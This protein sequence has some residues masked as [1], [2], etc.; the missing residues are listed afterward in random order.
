MIA[1]PAAAAVYYAASKGG[2]ADG[3]TLAVYDLGGGT[4]D[5]T[6]VQS[7]AEGIV[8]LGY[9]GDR[10]SRRQQ[11][12]RSDV[13]A[14]QRRHRRRAARARLRRRRRPGGHPGADRADAAALR[15]RQGSA[16]RATPPPPS[17]VVLPG[18]YQS[19]PLTREQFERMIRGWLEDTIALL[20]RTLHSAHVPAEQLSA[21]LLVG[22]SSRI[23]LVQQ[24]VAEA[25][26][27]PGRRHPP[28]IRRRPGRGDA[29]PRLRHRRDA[30]PRPAAPP[31]GR[32]RLGRP[33]ETMVLPPVPGPAT[34]GTGHDPATPC[35][36]TPRPAITAA[37]RARPG[38]PRTGRAG[39][40]PTPPT[41]PDMHRPRLADPDIPATTEGT[42][43]DAGGGG[44]DTD[45]PVP[46]PAR[47]A[48]SAGAA[49]RGA[50]PAKHRRWRSAQCSWFVA[51][52]L[53]AVRP[54]D[55]AG[56]AAGRGRPRPRPGAVAVPGA[57]P[58][59]CRRKRR[60]R[61]AADPPTGFPAI[62]ASSATP[63]TRATIN[64]GPTPG[65]A[66]AQ[67]RYV[68]IAQRASEDGSRSS[69]P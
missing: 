42:R 54:S 59:P 7:C 8:V 29:G 11:L 26:G 13:R 16:V 52:A 68:Y 23:P 25:F 48:G 45:P 30:G 53:C 5:A 43:L 46:P 21:V 1:E 57:N 15:G 35:R 51:A 64:V 18:L 49:A 14:L 55:V 24:M 31:R 69:T 60:P 36:P 61:T 17:P 38:G 40:L 33:E 19:V 50:V 10:A 20:Q 22:A 4:F 62:A 66:A 32:R 37:R 28:E 44:T 27:G 56:P 63:T 6:V 12:R 67:G 47:R 9:R 41:G 2:L 3:E 34:R 65:F 39:R 58:A